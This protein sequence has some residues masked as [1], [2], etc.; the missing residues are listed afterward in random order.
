MP[1]PVRARLAVLICCALVF[2]TLVVARQA[3]ASG[4]SGQGGGQGQTR[5][6]TPERGPPAADLPNLDEVRRKR[7]AKPQAPPHVPSLMR[8]RR[9]PLMPRNGLKVGDPGTTALVR[10]GSGS[11]RLASRNHSRAR[12][13]AGSLPPV[14]D[15]Q[16]VQTF[17][18]YALPSNTNQSQRDYFTDMLRAAYA[19]GQTS[20]VMA[21]RELG[22][23]LFESAE[24]AGRNRSNH[25]YVYDL[26]KTYLLR[27]PDSGG[28]AFWESLVPTYG[29]EA[30]R[31]AF[32]E[33]GEFIYDVST[34]NT[35]NISPRMRLPLCWQRGSIQ[36]INRA[37]KSWR[38]TLSL[39]SRS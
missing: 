34:I 20:M 7:H 37:I 13:H 17:F 16:Y 24:Y 38:A 5:R 35:N 21:A 1:V 22:K 30:I 10:T 28:W 4:A 19:P 29:R 14:G 27:D 15:D 25:D 39:R 32:D 18:S 11:D 9:K 3:A 31:R 6:G 12:A 33:S 8:G 2:S 26:Y 36:R 23:T